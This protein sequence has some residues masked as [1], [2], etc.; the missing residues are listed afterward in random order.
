M[1]NRF[2][3]LSLALVFAVMLGGADGCASD[4]QVEGAKLYLR[5]GE[6]EQAMSNLDAALTTDP[7]NAEALLLRAQ[8]LQAQAQDER[9]PATRQALVDRLVADL[10]RVQTLAPG[11]ADQQRLAAWAFTLQQ[12]VNVLQRDDP[13]PAVASALLRSSI[14]L[15][16]DS[17]QGH[18][19]LGIA[20]IQAGNSQAAIA[21]LQRSVALD[22]NAT[23]YYY[24]GRSQLLSDMGTDALTTYEAGAALFPD[25]ANLTTALLDAYVRTGQTDRAIDRYDAALRTAEGTPE[26]GLLRYNYGSL[27]LQAER[28]DEAVTQLRR[29]IV[30]NPENA[31]AQYNLGATYNNQARAI[32][33][34]ANETQDNA[35]AERLIAQRDQLLEQAL[36][37]LLRARTLSAGTETET[38]VCG[39]LFRVFAQL[40]R[41]DEAAEANACFTGESMR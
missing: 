25:D 21:P 1:L 26:E 36:E 34:Q 31:D 4:P 40:G 15:Q 27:L 22:P 18:Y 33:D 39:A 32:S 7:D 12:S 35:E 38:N 5:N 6:Y 28:Y 14:Q 24:L 10:D 19:N 37:P 16:P 9:D 20:Q 8:V 29:A 17:A 23:A 2:S 13:D 11:T 41:T 3:F 30:L